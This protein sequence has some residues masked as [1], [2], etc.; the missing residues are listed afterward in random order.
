MIGSLRN[1]AK[2]KL[3]AVFVFIIII[4]FVFWGMGSMFNTGNTNNI[5]KIDNTNIS[6]QDFMKYINSSGVPE[7]TIRENI[8]QNIIEEL[9]S[10]LISTTLL[11]LE[12]KDFEIRFSENA[13]LKKIKQNKNFLDENNQFT[14]IKYEKFLLTNNISAPI[15]ESRLKNRELQKQLFDYIGAG[16]KLP[17]FMLKDIFE[18]ENKKIN[19]KYIDLENIYKSKNRI[20]E[21]DIKLFLDKNKEQLKRDYIDFSYIIITPKKLVGIDEFNEVFFNK[22]DEIENE[23][24]NNYSFNE[25]IKDL[26]IKKQTVKN[27]TLIEEKK[28]G[29]K[30]KIFNL[31]KNKI[32]LIENEDSYIL[33]NIDGEQS[34]PPDLNNEKT[35][36]EII[37]LVYEKNKFEYNKDLF[38][39]IQNKN[40]DDKKFINIGND[41]IKNTSINSIIDNKL[42]EIN[43]VELLYSL[44]LKSF[45]ILADEQE[46]F[47][48]VK[49]ESFDN[50][51]FN[52]KNE[53]HNSFIQKYKSNQKSNI[54]KSYDA[55]LN[56]K[57][58]IVLNQKTI[59]R[60]K[61]YFK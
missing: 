48:L 40:F 36:K 33:F 52:S 39:E 50:Q 13:I 23:I 57:Y 41:L 1:F 10:N 51:F 2:T 61:N 4:P 32:D 43:S 35:K 20:S 24:S 55:F 37:N 59:D 29:V 31:R 47:Y 46:N 53:K 3:A 5:A 54:L 60:V 34:L 58:D 17:D 25:I 49:I 44:P 28:D 26:S 27:Y 38:E 30:N 12:I 9:L 8:D 11:D 18:E 15:F 14:R 6:T 45:T 22:I 16:T 56:D 42:F 21:N 19:I 7:K